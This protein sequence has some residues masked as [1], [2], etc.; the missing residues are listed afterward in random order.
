ML[1]Y[2]FASNI[3]YMRGNK[4]CLNNIP[5]KIM[6]SCYYGMQCTL[7][8]LHFFFWLVFNV[9]HVHLFLLVFLLPLKFYGDS[10]VFTF[11]YN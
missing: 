2:C 8:N 1:L 9:L 5:G 11:I 4:N 3:N 7:R 10:N 6:M